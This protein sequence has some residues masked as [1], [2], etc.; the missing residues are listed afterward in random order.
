MDTIHLLASSAMH[1]AI[2]AQA[3][4]SK[5]FSG[6]SSRK[7]WS[8]ASDCKE[9]TIS[10]VGLAKLLQSSNKD[11]HTG[12]IEVVVWKLRYSVSSSY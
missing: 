6:Q 4:T 1:P 5:Q 9:F 7:G 3:P 8:P 11:Y 12:P 2:K 10:L